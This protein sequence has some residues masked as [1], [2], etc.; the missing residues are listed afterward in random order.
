MTRIFLIRHG[1]N[2]DGQVDGQGPVVDLGLSAAGR[3]QVDRLCARLLASGEHNAAVLLASPERRAVETAQAVSAVLGLQLATDRRLEEWRSDD[4]SIPQEEFMAQWRA[5]REQDRAYH[6]FQPQS[7]SQ[8]EF[9]A[10]VGE[11]LHSIA[12]LYAGANVL[13]ITHGG[14]IQASFRH[15]FGFGDAAFRRAYP[16]VAHTSL[17]LWREDGNS[18]RWTLEYSNDASHTERA[19]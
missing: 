13:V 9:F 3:T 4:G 7:E 18:G 14:F 2:I 5:L 12:R 16:A 8:A 10:R 11:A 6:G 1:E 19:A 17:T 15:F